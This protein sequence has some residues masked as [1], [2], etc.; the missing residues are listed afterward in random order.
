MRRKRSVDANS[1][2]KSRIPAGAAVIQPAITQA[3]TRAFFEEWAERGYGALSLENVARRAGVGKAAL[4]RRWRSKADMAGDTLSAVGV[5]ITEVEATGSLKGDI[6]ALLFSIRRVLRHP[7]VRRIVPDVHAEISRSSDLRAAVRPFQAARR[8]HVHLMIDRAMARG[9]LAPPIDY[10]M[11]ADLIAAPI[12]WRQVVT[13][14]RADR[15]YVETLATVLFVS[16][17]AMRPSDRQGSGQ[18]L[19]GKPQS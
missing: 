1:P 6:L 7:V 2:V 18:T 16:I 8:Q 4:Y 17:T 15:R 9:E 13:G 11:V 3:L 10:E 19:V 5:A 14:G 12:Y